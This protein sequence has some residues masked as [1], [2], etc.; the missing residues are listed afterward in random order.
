MSGGGHYSH[1]WSYKGRMKYQK[2]SYWNSFYKRLNQDHVPTS[3]RE[4]VKE[5]ES[6]LAPI[7]S[8]ILKATKRYTS[9]PENSKY[10]GHFFRSDNRKNI[11]CCGA[12]GKNTFPNKWL[13]FN[14]LTSPPN[15]WCTVFRTKPTVTWKN[16][17]SSRRYKNSCRSPNTT[18]ML[19]EHAYRNIRA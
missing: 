5:V 8:S 1:Y 7:V 6:F 15:A 14:T 13:W 16:A 2:Q 10:L 4:I 17:L 12:A 9:C 3:F 18:M 11:N 19:I